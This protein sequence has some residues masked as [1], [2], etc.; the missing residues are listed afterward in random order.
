MAGSY[1]SSSPS[2]TTR[3]GGGGGGG[4]RA[5]E[6][7][8]SDELDDAAGALLKGRLSIKRLAPEAAA[9][10]ERPKLLLRLLLLL[11]ASVA[12]TPVI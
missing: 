4:G 2:L 9:P 7:C 11:A 3:G 8:D 5:E 10:V 1:K 6:P 12:L